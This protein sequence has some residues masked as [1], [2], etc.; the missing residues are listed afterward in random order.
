VPLDEAAILE[1]RAQGRVFNRQAAVR[2]ILQALFEKGLPDGM[3]EIR[4]VVS[5]ATTVSVEI[6]FC[7]QQRGPFLGLP[8]TGRELNLPMVI[9]GQPAAGHIQRIALYYDAGTLLRQLGLAL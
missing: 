5:D 8:N 4:C 1:D 3:R 2:E 7:G 9:I 6:A